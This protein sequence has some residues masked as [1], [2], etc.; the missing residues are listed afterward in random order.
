MDG[1]I[2]RRPFYWL[3]YRLSDAADAPWHHGRMVINGDQF[4]LN[5]EVEDEAAAP[6]PRLSVP[7]DQQ[8]L[9]QRYDEGRYSDKDGGGTYFVHEGKLRGKS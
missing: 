1:P 2:E 8:N 5:L 3:D 6:F 7:L 9:A 4:V